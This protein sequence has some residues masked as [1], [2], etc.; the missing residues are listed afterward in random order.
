MYKDNKQ[1]KNLPKNEFN[2]IFWRSFSLL[3][4]FNYERLTIKNQEVN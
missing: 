1:T 2:S 3:G 4:S